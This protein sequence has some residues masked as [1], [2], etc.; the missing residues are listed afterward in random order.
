MNAS[1]PTATAAIAPATT[2]RNWIGVI[3]AMLGA[4]MAVLDIQITNSSLRDISG[5]IGA[6]L[7]ESSWISIA[8]L[9]PEIIVIPLTGWITS[10]FG[11]RRYMMVTAALFL[12]FSALCGHAW[13]LG[14]MI[15]FRV[16]QGFFGGAL[17]PLAF[18]AVITRLPPARHAV[19]F[20]MFGLTAMFAPS[21]GPSIG[22]WLTDHWGWTWN[23]YLNLLL[24]PF[25]I[26]G[27]WYGF[28]REPIQWAKLQQFDGWGILLMSLGLGSLTTLLEEGTR[29]D[30]F[31]SP[32]IVRLTVIAAVS[33]PLFVVRELTAKNPVAD[34][35]VFANRNFS[36]GSIV[37]T[38]FGAALYGSV[39]LVPTYL[40]SIQNYGASDIG[41][42][43]IWGG[44]PQ[45]FIMPL[46]P[47]FIA[48]FDLRLLI[49]FGLAMFAASSFMNTNL[50]LDSAHDQLRWAL[51]VR[52]LGMPFI[53]VPLASLT[54]AGMPPGVSGL[55]NMMRNLGGSIGIA[56]LSAGLTM[57]EQFHSNRLGEAV[58]LYNP[59]TQDRLN[60]FTTKF[61]AAGADAWTAS[62]QAVVALDSIVR[63][64][65]TISA[66]N[67]CFRLLTVA[68]LLGVVAVVLCRPAPRGGTAAPAH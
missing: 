40:S 56:L 34:L 50:S 24:G 33:L 51:L 67:D 63:R 35:R 49:A 9:V 3:G 58:S 19:G 29:D 26:G 61:A 36:L 11:L 41:A 13:S 42:T 27:V 5:S 66:F 48:R 8:Y 16:G 12:L 10:I 4:F 45:L 6:S 30:W 59:L 17:I 38:I 25:L 62:Q 57:R 44:I 53:M 23:F 18:S 15:A 37:N 22:G 43:L 7:D 14:S 2:T 65:A 64:E 1:A 47:K 54:T 20:A 31:G 68:L 21:I 52:A 60:A 32:F 55:F 46:M 39:F 28:E